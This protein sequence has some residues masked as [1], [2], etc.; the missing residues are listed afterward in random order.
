MKP[1]AETNHLI[2][3]EDTGRS[4]TNRFPITD[5]NYHSVAIGAYNGRCLKGAPSFLKISRDYFKAEARRS[6]VIE[7]VLFAVITVTAAPA[8][9]DCGRALLEFMRS[10]GAM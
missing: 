7:A 8:I 5:C 3:R 6:F 1:T 2:K 10:I 9:V 4:W